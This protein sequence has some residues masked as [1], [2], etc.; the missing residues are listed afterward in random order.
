MPDTGTSCEAGAATKDAGSVDAGATV[1]SK[2]PQR[3]TL[4][5]Q[6]W[7]APRTAGEVTRVA[8]EGELLRCLSD[9]VRDVDADFLLGFD[10]EKLSWGYLVRRGDLLGV[11][12]EGGS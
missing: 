2:V 10:L 5:Q 1:A 11:H 12:A 8:S 6:R 3:S 7:L 4:P 9:K